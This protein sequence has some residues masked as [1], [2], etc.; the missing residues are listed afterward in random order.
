M[1]YSLPF[2]HH[3]KTKPERRP[4]KP[5]VIEFNQKSPRKN[6]NNLFIINKTFKQSTV[7]TIKA[8]YYKMKTYGPKM[9]RQK[10]SRRGTL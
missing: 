6:A 9:R 8:D 3:N 4:S 2:D 7:I 10:V 1:V 5:F